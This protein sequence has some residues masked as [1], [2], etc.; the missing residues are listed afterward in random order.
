MSPVPLLN[1]FRIF[2]IRYLPLQL[3]SFYFHSSLHFKVNI[4]S[5]LKLCMLFFI[6]L[7][8]KKLTHILLIPS[9]DAIGRLMKTYCID[10]SRS[11]ISQQQ[12]ISEIFDITSK[13]FY[14][15]SNT[16]PTSQVAHITRDFGTCYSCSHYSFM[17]KHISSFMIK[18]FRTIQALLF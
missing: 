6:M 8:K 3:L 7:F 1:A 15:F 18:N 16:P 13:N 12:E 17:H 5:F 11:F 9:R 4:K 14:I 10:Q 2:R